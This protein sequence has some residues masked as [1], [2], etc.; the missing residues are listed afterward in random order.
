VVNFQADEVRQI[1]RPAKVH[2]GTVADDPG[3]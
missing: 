3:R 1:E 2:R